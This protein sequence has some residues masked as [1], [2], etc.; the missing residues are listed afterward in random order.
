MKITN[1]FNSPKFGGLYIK[2]EVLTRLASLCSQPYGGGTCQ[3]AY[4]ALR[5][6]TS[7]KDVL[8]ES[9]KTGIIA[10][11]I[12]AD[13]WDKVEIHRDTDFVRGMKTV[14]QILKEGDDV[15][16]SPKKV[17]KASIKPEVID[18]RR[19]NTLV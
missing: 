11:R 7:D 17:N 4:D 18:A 3:F 10:S 15:K 8:L 16:F 1:N 9:Y 12:D 6:A 13:T 19:I 2:G 14:T 5:K